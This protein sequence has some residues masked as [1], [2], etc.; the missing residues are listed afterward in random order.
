VAKNLVRLVFEHVDHLSE[1]PKSGKP[2][3]EFEASV[4][5]EIK[6]PLCRIFYRIDDHIVYIIHMIR[7]EQFLHINILKSR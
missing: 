7:E 4:Y 5:R 2:L 3:E 6:L 1:H